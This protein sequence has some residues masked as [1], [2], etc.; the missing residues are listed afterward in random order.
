MSAYTDSILKTIASKNFG[1]LP[2]AVDLAA[3]AQ[4]SVEETQKCIEKFR[5][6]NKE[7]LKTLAADYQPPEIKEQTETVSV[8]EVQMVEQEER[9]DRPV[10]DKVRSFGEKVSRVLDIH[11]LLNEGTIQLVFSIIVILDVYRH[12]GNYHQFFG[13][14]QDQQTAWVSSALN[15]MPLVMLPAAIVFAFRR[16]MYAGVIIMCL[17]FVPCVGFSAYVTAENL[18]FSHDE[19]REV[20]NKDVGQ[21]VKNQNLIKILEAEVK[22]LESKNAELLA[23]NAQVRGKLGGDS[24]SKDY[25]AG[26]RVINSNEASMRKN[27]ATILE[28]RNELKKLSQTTDVNAVVESKKDVEDWMN[29]AQAI[30]LDLIGISAVW[31]AFFLSPSVQTIQRQH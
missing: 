31:I 19:K 16:K 12:F 6:D 11:N 25:K 15:A 10:T 5:Q 14:I 9:L 4:M 30:F 23:Q 8:R 1:K 20:V 27:D 17:T 3:K 21:D 18:A 2:R 7:W 13:R 28:D 22:D 29:W 24:E 26:I